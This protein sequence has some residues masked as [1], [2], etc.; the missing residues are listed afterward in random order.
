[1][2]AEPL[3][4][5]ADATLDEA[6]LLMSELGVHHLPIVSGERPIGMVGLRDVT[7]SALL[8]R[9]PIGLGF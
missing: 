9:A 6:A 5:P 4:V 1:M 3:S 8:D 2:T 7:R